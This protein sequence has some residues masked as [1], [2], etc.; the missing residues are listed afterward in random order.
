MFEIQHQPV[1]R[2]PINQLISL[3]ATITAPAGIKSV[4][5][6][7]RSVNQHLDYKTLPMLANAGSDTYQVDIPANQIDATFDLMYFIEIIDT[8]GNGTIY[9][10]LE[11]ETPYVIVE[12]ER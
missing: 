3:K 7:Y 10:N 12:L 2:A 9:P 8:N 11:K 6:R 1:T 4:N 5:L